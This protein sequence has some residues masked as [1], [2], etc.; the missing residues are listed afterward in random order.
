MKDYK[1][2]GDKIVDNLG[3][4]LKIVDKSFLIEAFQKEN[5]QI[6]D[7]KAELLFRFYE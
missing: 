6:S 1:Q 3:K 7:E 4:N 5:F 2:I